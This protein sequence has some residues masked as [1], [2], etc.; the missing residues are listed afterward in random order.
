V[1]GAEPG[2]LDADEQ[3][4][5]A[6]A[7]SGALELEHKLAVWPGYVV[8]DLSAAGELVARP[9][10]ELHLVATYYD[11]ADLRLVRSGASLRFRIGEETGTWTLKLPAGEGAG[12]RDA[13]A[14][15]ELDVEAPGDAVP[16]RLRWLTYGLSRGAGLRPVCVV[17][18]TRRRILIEGDAGARLGELDDDLVVTRDE[19]GRP[20]RSFRELELELAAVAPAE[21]VDAVLRL[22]RAAGA[23]SAPAMPKVVRA[24][25]PPAAS[26]VD[27]APPEAIETVEDLVRTAL[28]GDLA[29]VM[30]HEVGTRLGSDPEDLHQARVGLRRFRADLR[31]FAAVLDAAAVEPLAREVAWLGRAL[32]EVR[33]ADVLADRLDDEV[34]GLPPG[35]QEAAAAVRAELAAQRSHARARLEEALATPRY[36]ALLESLVGTVLAPP[37]RVEGRAA[38]WAGQLLVTPWRRLRRA[39][40]HLGAP[41]APE[42][43]HELRIKAKRA[44]YAA[45]ALEPVVGRPAR[46]LAAR[47]A[48]LQDVLGTFHDAAVLEEWLRRGV[49]PATPPAQ[50]LVVGE[51]VGSARAVAAASARAWP[52]SWRRARDAAKRAGW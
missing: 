47:L 18:T 30:A 10:A 26:P 17:E 40:R 11:T 9:L 21:Q 35:D 27:W 51:L 2:E 46:E 39:A 33:D 41:P 8:P 19:D 31:T 38:D 16:D 7:P 43:L 48:P 28:A 12:A 6:P 3:G 4:D 24:L 5:R 34:A 50:A 13:L 25:G 1:S 44:R 52:R 23:R 20:L 22:L 14:R 29:R 32:G 45:E 49:G 37:V 15:T 36:A 42:E